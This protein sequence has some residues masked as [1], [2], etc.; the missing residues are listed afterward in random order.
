MT[1]NHQSSRCPAVTRADVIGKVFVVF[2]QDV[3]KCLVCEQLFTRR[4]FA[5][6]AT[7]V[8]YPAHF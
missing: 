3:R 2:G 5:E 8:C 7:V 6:H 1:T 4:A